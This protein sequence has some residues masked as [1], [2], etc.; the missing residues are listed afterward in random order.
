MAKAF[1]KV[2]LVATGSGIGPVLSLLYAQN[3]DCRILWSTPDPEATYKKSILEHVRHGDPDA[4]IM[5]TTV[6]GRPNLVQLAYDLYKTSDAE[7]VFIISNPRVTR[8][9]VY[10][11]ESRGVPTFAPIFDS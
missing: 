9:F 3:L 6:S 8:K 1:R 7:A 5:N 11:L 4:I 2:V 10:A